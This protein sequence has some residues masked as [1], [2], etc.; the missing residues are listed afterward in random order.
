MEVCFITRQE[1]D[2]GSFVQDRARRLPDLE[3][4]LEQ[5]PWL[6]KSPETL[7]ERSRVLGRDIESAGSAAAEFHP[8]R[9]GAAL[10][11]WHIRHDFVTVRQKIDALVPVIESCHRLA[12][13]LHDIREVRSAAC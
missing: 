11:F 6:P 2:T 12:S 7:P 1:R 8:P 13:L 3:T 10:G 9:L 4:L 5:I